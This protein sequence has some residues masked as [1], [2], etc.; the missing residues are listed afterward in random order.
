MALFKLIKFFESTLKELEQAKPKTMLY[1]WFI[2]FRIKNTKK[3]IA[4]L[5]NELAIKKNYNSPYK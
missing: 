4:I 3:R 1:K 5:R 2:D